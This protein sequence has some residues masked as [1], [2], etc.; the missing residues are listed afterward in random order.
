MANELPDKL[1]RQDPYLSSL[2]KIEID[3]VIEAGFSECSGLQVE[4]EFEEYREGGVNEFVHRLPKLTKYQTITL[5]RG[6]TESDKLWNWHQE[7]IK[8]KFSVS[9]RKGGSIILLDAK[10]EEKC[11]WSFVG[12]Y[13]VKWVGPDLRADQGAI[14]VETLELVHHGLTKA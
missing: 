14:A 8:G 5:K 3:G 6:R 4:T 1:K 7:V 11:R 9:T 12:A 10:G 13:P 2:F